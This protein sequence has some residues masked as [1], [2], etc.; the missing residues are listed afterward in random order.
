MVKNLIKKKFFDEKFKYSIDRQKS[1]LY[2]R[3]TFKWL[4]GKYTNFEY[5]MWV[6]IFSGK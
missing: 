5:L 3:F 4:E 1:F 6:N 2:Y